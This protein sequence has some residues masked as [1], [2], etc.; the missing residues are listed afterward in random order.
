MLLKQQILFP[1]TQSGASVT[2]VEAQEFS[3]APCKNCL[4]LKYMVLHS[5]GVVNSVSNNVESRSQNSVL[6]FILQKN[7]MLIVLRNI[8][9]CKIEFQKY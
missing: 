2:V 1:L 6:N 9:Y 7:L 8:F 3:R 4:I 5:Q